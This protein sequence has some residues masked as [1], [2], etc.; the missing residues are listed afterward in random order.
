MICVGTLPECGDSGGAGYAE[1]LADAVRGVKPHESEQ[2]IRA[3]AGEQVVDLCWLARCGHR[4]RLGD[5]NRGAAAQPADRTN[6]WP[7]QG[8]EL[9][10]G[11][12][13][14]TV[15]AHPGDIRTAG[16]PL[17]QVGVVLA[18]A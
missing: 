5:E 17:P 7:E 12:E 8:S 3:D 4:A 15:D 16:P 1:W 2:A 9:P 18:A 11:F 13:V 14:V 10:V 6:S